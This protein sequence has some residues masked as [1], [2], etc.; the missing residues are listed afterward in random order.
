MLMNNTWEKYKYV[1]EMLKRD[2]LCIPPYQR[3]NGKFIDECMSFTDDVK[4]LYSKISETVINPS[5]RAY[6]MEYKFKKANIFS[7]YIPVI[8]YSVYDALQGNWICAY[9]SLL[10]VVEA[11]LRK[12]AAEYPSLSFNKMKGFGKILSKYL[13]NNLQVF[14]D[15]RITLV[16]EHIDFLRHM[17]TEVLYVDFDA[18]EDAQFTDI[19]NRNLALH[20]LEG[21]IDIRTGLH[22]V[23]RTLLIIDIIAE[24]YIMQNPQVW[25]QNI[26]YA[27]PET[28]VDY[29]LRWQLYIKCAMLSIGPNDLRIIENAFLNRASDEIKKAAT[30]KLKSEIAL[31]RKGK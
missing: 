8:E 22:N 31:L 27:T 14:D 20:K 5:Q 29:Q 16:N 11:L 7:Q 2:F 17:I 15:D 10:P 4:Q 21:V 26:F 23:T 3:V 19:F 18:Y 25:W 13:Q 6:Q 24:L 30:D 28:D 9:L 12:W 1:N